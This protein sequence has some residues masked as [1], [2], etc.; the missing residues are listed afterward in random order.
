[1]D[2]RD[3]LD[4]IPRLSGRQMRALWDAGRELPGGRLRPGLWLGRNAAMPALMEWM[5]RRVLGRAWFA[6][7]VLDGWGVNVRVVQ[8]GSHALRPG[9]DGNAL[10]VDLPFAIT[11]RGLDYGCH[12]AGYEPQL[13][14]MRDHL[15][16]V[17]AAAVVEVAGEGG[18]D[19]PA[20]ELV[21][22]YLA[23][24]AIAALR[25]APFAMMW[26]REATGDEEAAAV[27]WLGQRRWLDS[28]VPRG[29]G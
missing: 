15:R 27:A 28:A 16:V 17:D 6:K 14:Q 21:I 8:D 10:E 12:L 23:P 9:R 4:L 25:G 29:A 18:G 2:V 3:A 13:L 26:E 24:L 20:G 5:I 11:G 7:L 1:M 22:G 19:P